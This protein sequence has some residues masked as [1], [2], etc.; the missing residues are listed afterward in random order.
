MNEFLALTKAFFR[1]ELRTREVSLVLFTSVLLIAVLLAAGTGTAFLDPFITRKVFPLIFWTTI[2]TASSLGLGRAFESEMRNGV[3]EALATGGAQLRK[4]FFA[5]QLVV[6]LFLSATMIVSFYVLAAVFQISES[7][8]SNTLLPLFI[9]LSLA[10][11]ALGNLLSV[12]A[13]GSALRSS[14]LPLLFIPCC[15]PLFFASLELTHAAILGQNPFELPWF[16]LSLFMMVLYS[17]L[18]ALLFPAAVKAQF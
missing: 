17:L 1:L 16:G 13:L 10:Y 7:Q 18:G 4:V 3:L 6:A 11:A 5:K 15:F 9:I 14:L 2:V 8:T 12:V